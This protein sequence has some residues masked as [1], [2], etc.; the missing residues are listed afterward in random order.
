VK[1]FTCSN[2]GV[3]RVLYAGFSS[4]ATKPSEEDFSVW[5]SKP[6]PRTQCNS[7]VIRVQREASMRGTRDVIVGPVSEGSKATVDVCSLDEDTHIFPR[8]P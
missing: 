5:A 6:S 2:L 3:V 8:L 4:L 7:D 1:G